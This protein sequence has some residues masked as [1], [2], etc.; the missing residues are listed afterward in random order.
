MEKASIK[1]Y[2]RQTGGFVN[3]EHNITLHL[4]HTQELS[5]KEKM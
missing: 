4:L 5:R 2:T 3:H 1:P